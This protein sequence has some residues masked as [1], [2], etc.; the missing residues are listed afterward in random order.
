MWVHPCCEYLI[1]LTTG[2]VAFQESIRPIRTY[3]KLLTQVMETHPKLTVQLVLRPSD[4]YDPFLYSWRNLIRWVTVVFACFLIYDTSSTWSSALS[5]AG[6][7]PAL[8]IS[9]LVGFALF[10]LFV[11][12]WL[13]VQSMFRKYPTLRRPRSF[14]FS[15]EGMHAESEDA[16]GDYKWSLFHRIV[17]TPKLFLFMSTPRGATYVP[18]RCLSRPDEIGI[19]RQLIRENFKGKK[20]LR[21][22]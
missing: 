3:A 10:I 13:R 12:P 20:T 1:S 2:Q 16:R 19:L 22:E 5:G 7:K 21:R 11:L 14:S 9:F 6:I 18:K 8:L 15:S 4:V 17:E